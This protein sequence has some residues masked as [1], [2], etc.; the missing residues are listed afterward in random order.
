MFQM[1]NQCRHGAA[2]CVS[3]LTTPACKIIY[4]HSVTCEWVTAVCQF[5]TRDGT[6]RSTIARG[7]AFLPARPDTR[8][9]W[10]AIFRTGAIFSRLSPLPGPVRPSDC[11][12]RAI[13][14][15]KKSRRVAIIARHSPDTEGSPQLTSLP[16]R[17]ALRTNWSLGLI[18]CLCLS[19]WRQMSEK[20]GA[21]GWRPRCD[22]VTFLRRPEAPVTCGMRASQNVREELF[23]GFMER[24]ENLVSLSL[25]GSREQQCTERA[26][27]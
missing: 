16:S 19:N 23:R 14:E 21:P 15:L 3:V 17:M 2:R 9:Q 4:L 27:D 10:P 6:A 25:A 13:V 26:E 5:P 20:K 22:F 12:A 18:F 11:R 8:G 1:A 7:L 24:R